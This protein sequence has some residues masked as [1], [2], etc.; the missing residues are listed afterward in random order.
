MTMTKSMYAM[1]MGCTV[2]FGAAAAVAQSADTADMDKQ[3]LMKASQSDYTE[4]QFS[5][6]ALQQ[7]TNPQ[8]KAYAQKMVDDHTKLEAEMK[9]F[10]D[11]LGVTP[12]TTL[13]AEH[14]QKYDALKQMSGMNFDKT[15]MTGMDQDHHIALDLFKQQEKAPSSDPA[16]KKTVEKGEKVVAM[17]TKMA[18]AAVQKMDKMSAKSGASGMA[19]M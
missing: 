11:K 14:Q 7:A 1:I 6:L 5:Q 17:H 13:D 2:A 19:G 10:A 9:P 18:D 16:M 3:F 8:V 15:Y 4:I 12:V